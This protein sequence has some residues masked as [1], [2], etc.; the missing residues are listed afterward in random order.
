MQVADFVVSE[1][2]ALLVLLAAPVPGSLDAAGL[3]AAELDA[4]RVHVD[5]L[6]GRGAATVSVAAAQEIERQAEEAEQ[7]RKADAVTKKK[8]DEEAE[9]KKEGRGGGLGGGRGGTHLDRDPTASAASD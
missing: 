8:A 1:R 3:T 2:G 7:K 9:A 5:G 6:T 4:L